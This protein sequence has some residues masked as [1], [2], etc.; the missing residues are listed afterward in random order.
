MSLG[1][2]NVSN[3]QLLQLLDRTNC[4]RIVDNLTHPYAGVRSVLLNRD[5]DTDH[6]LYLTVRQT[7]EILHN[8]GQKK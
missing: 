4:S 2:L 6:V 5:I 1:G 7:G 3:A 8:N